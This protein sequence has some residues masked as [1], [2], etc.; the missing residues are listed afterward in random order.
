MAIGRHRHV[1]SLG[2]ILSPAAPAAKLLLRLVVLHAGVLVFCSLA[3][4]LLAAWPAESGAELLRAD[5]GAADRICATVCDVM[6]ALVSAALGGSWLGGPGSEWLRAHGGQLFRPEGFHPQAGGGGGGGGGPYFEGWYCRRRR[7]RRPAAAAAAAAAARH[8]CDVH[9]YYKAVLQPDGRSL[10][11][12]PGVLLEPAAGKALPFDCVSTAFLSKTVP[13]L[14][15]LQRRGQARGLR[16]AGD[17]DPDL[18]L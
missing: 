3:H 12:I 7:R 4:H 6:H 8:R 18:G 11:L 9:R 17:P 5:Y 15:V 1:G 2:S 10:V 16:P 13:F 14:A